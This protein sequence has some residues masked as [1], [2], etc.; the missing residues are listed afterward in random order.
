MTV[1]TISGNCAN[2]FVPQE[3]EANAI[4][5]LERWRIGEKEICLQR[6]GDQLSYEILDT[7]TG[8]TTQGPI[9]FAERNIEEVIPYL[10]ECQPQVLETG[11]IKF[12]PK[13][14][15]PYIQRWI[16]GDREIILRRNED[17]LICEVFN[18]ITYQSKHGSIGLDRH[19][20]IL[21]HPLRC[22]PEVLETGVSFSLRPPP[23]YTWTFRNKELQLWQKDQDLV[24][25][26]FDKSTKTVSQVPFNVG[27]LNS[28]EGHHCFSPKTSHPS[29]VYE[30]L[31]RSSQKS[32]KSRL[33]IF[34]DCE[35]E[36]LEIKFFPHSSAFR[37]NAVYAKKIVRKSR[38]DP[39]VPIDRTRW[40]V[41]LINSGDSVSNP[42][43]WGGHAAIIIEGRRQGAFFT[44]KAHLRKINGK[45]VVRLE[46]IGDK[47]I[48]YSQKGETWK[49]NRG[50]AKRMLEA[51]SY[52]LEMQEM[53]KH[54]KKNLQE[55][56]DPLVFFDLRGRGSKLAKPYVIKE[57]DSYDELVRDTLE[58]ECVDS[59]SSLPHPIPYKSITLIDKTGKRRILDNRQFEIQ[60]VQISSPQRIF[61]QNPSNEKWSEVRLPDNCQTWAARKLEYCGI[62]LKS[63]YLLKS[64]FALPRMYMAQGL[65]LQ[66]YAFSRLFSR[67]NTSEQSEDLTPLM[68]AIKEGDVDKVEDLLDTEID[69][70]AK[71]NKGFNAFHL[72]CEI[73]AT[74]IVNL[75]H[76]K[77][78]DIN[79]PADDYLRS[80]PLFLAIKNN[81]ERLIWFLLKLGAKI[82]QRDAKT[83][84]TILHLIS[85]SCSSDLVLPEIF[86]KDNVNS[87]NN[88]GVTPLMLAV[89]SRKIEMAHQLL[90]NKAL[91]D[92]K[93]KWGYTALWYAFHALSGAYHL[94]DEKIL[95]LLVK[96]GASLDTA[97]GQTKYTLLQ[98]AIKN[99][100]L[101]LARLL[102]QNKASVDQ[103]D[104]LG[105]TA[106]W[107]AYESGDEEMVKLLI[108]YGANLNAVFNG[109]H[110]PL[111]AALIGKKFEMACVFLQN[112]ASVDQKD[113][114]GHTALWYAYSKRDVEMLQLLIE[115]G[116][117]LHAVFSERG[118]PPLQ[119]AVIDKKLEMA[120]VFLQN[121]ASINEKNKSGNTAL[122]YAY[123]NDDAEMVKL[124]IEYGAN[125][126]AAFSKNGLTP[127]QTAVKDKKL[128]MARLFL[129][130]K[131]SVDQKNKY[132][133]TALWYAYKNEDEE[134][135]RLLIEYGANV[136]NNFDWI[137]TPLLAAVID[138]KFGMA[139]LFLQNKASVDRKHVL[140]NT[141]FEEAYRNNDKEMLHLLI[142]YRP[143]LLTEP[144]NFRDPPLIKAVKD[145]KYEMACLFL[146]NQVPIDAKDSLGLT[147]L[148]HACD[149]EDEEMVYLLIE[150]G[151]DLSAAYYQSEYSNPFALA[152]K[153]NLHGILSILSKALSEQSK[154]NSFCLLS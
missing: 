50:D 20:D 1:Y 112:K 70:N 45:A 30:V 44:Y 25:Q 114:W 98:V 103:K 123:Y 150:H 15:L 38:L 88:D 47:E 35:I 107:Y 28:D 97:F 140:L 55:E 131:V 129:Q 6:S 56:K 135:V 125:L 21:S 34:K 40:A 11:G 90:Q 23:R 14:P 72:A 108:E 86:I 68:R 146:Q 13:P 62:Y 81:H 109:R 54:D 122:W 66:D 39:S 144:N 139:R 42:L 17:R 124:L 148:W 149:N 118:L 120:R 142:A 104:E 111:Q 137:R 95:R 94:E 110:T 59:F 127:L 26:L 93:D 12:S 73:G 92:Q 46:Y 115:Y 29:S 79:E 61:I 105:N 71:N 57:Y 99:K 51:I 151:T 121:K 136:D 126:D 138:K 102:L 7:L 22:Q 64:I 143:H 106:L 145:K 77:G 89:V 53:K 32:P 67:M 141:P 154:K 100:K 3:K 119:A 19:K 41:T 130:N 58:P 52:E 116:A 82:D 24:W 60:D 2:Y 101:E 43:T 31:E 78:M 85:S 16:I 132:H 8:K 37:L 113:K 83:G 152:Y 49:V 153:R 91:V 36:K 75:L 33:N 9:D 65:A 74:R 133:Y 87:Q 48:S 76:K 4:Q 96:Y 5:H 69:L 128:E 84:N 117:S 80:T 27:F 10:L 147:A 18:T 63:D 134:M